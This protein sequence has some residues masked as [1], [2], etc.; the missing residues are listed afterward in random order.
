MI[1]LQ[2]IGY[3]LGVIA[4][5]IATLVF[6]MGGLSYRRPSPPEENTTPTTP[7]SRPNGTE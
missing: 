4:I 3:A 7:P 1:A 5:V 2:T 6:M